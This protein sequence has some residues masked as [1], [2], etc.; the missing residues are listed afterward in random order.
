MYIVCGVVCGAI[1]QGLLWAIWHMYIDVYE[2]SNIINSKS[3]ITL[4]MQNTEK[5]AMEYIKSHLNLFPVKL[6]GNK[7]KKGYPDFYC[8]NNTYIEIKSFDNQRVG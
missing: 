4:Y 7:H 6:H 8:G 1:P 5:I 2:S 3:S